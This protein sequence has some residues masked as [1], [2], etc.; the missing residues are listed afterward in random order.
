[1]PVTKRILDRRFET[2]NQTRAIK[3]TKDINGFK[4][5]LLGA[6]LTFNTSTI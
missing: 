4:A 5:T 3:K 1:M 2:A 6:V